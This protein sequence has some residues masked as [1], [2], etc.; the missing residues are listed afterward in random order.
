M[1]IHSVSFVTQDYE[2]YVFRDYERSSVSPENINKEI[3]HVDAY[4][5]YHPF[6][7]LR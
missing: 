7:A 4:I 2:I 6:K 5:I 1:L 3:K